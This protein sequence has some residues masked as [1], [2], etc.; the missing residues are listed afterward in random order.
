MNTT[1]FYRNNKCKAEAYCKIQKANAE[2]TG[3]CVPQFFGA[4]HIVHPKKPYRRIGSGDGDMP[5]VER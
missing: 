3:E 4:D 1:A 2:Y 5:Y